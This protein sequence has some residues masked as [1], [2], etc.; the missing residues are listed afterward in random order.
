MSDYRSPKLTAA[1][2][3]PNTRRNPEIQAVLTEVSRLYQS[4]T[5]T[6]CPADPINQQ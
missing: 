1:P 3:Y 2:A 4:L 6:S 5:L